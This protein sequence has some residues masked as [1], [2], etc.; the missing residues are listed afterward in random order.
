VEQTTPPTMVQTPKLLT[1]TQSKT[2]N[3]NIRN[4]MFLAQAVKPSFQQH[5]KMRKTVTP[6]SICLNL[7]PNKTTMAQNPK[8]LTKTQSNISKSALPTELHQ[9]NYF[10]THQNTKYTTTQKPVL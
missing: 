1:K 6:Q 9:T 5:Q 8:L 3:Q 2:N 7:K 10:Y 4:Q